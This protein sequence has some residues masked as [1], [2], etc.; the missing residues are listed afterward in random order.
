MSVHHCFVDDGNG[1]RMDLIDPNGCALD[2]YL[3]NHLD[4]PSDLM[5]GQESH[6]FKVTVVLYY[7]INSFTQTQ[8]NIII[9]ISCLYSTPIVQPYS[10]NVK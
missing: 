2:P 1:D 4:Y 7:M 9:I 5:A 8:H 6:V 3:L 10:F